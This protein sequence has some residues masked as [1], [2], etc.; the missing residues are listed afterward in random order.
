LKNWLRLLAK[1]PFSCNCRKGRESEATIVMTFSRGARLLFLALCFL[2]FPGS[3]PVH[4]LPVGY[5][6]VEIAPLSGGTES[7]AWDLNS[8][9][10]VVGLSDVGGDTVVHT[11][12]WTNGVS[13]DLGRFEVSVG[14]G[15]HINNTG[16]VV[17]S[18][19]FGSE[20]H[21]FLWENGITTD[22]GTLGGNR[23]QA[24]DVNNSGQV[25][26]VNEPSRHGFLW[27]NGSMIDLGTLGGSLST[28][29][30]I[31]KLGQI[32]GSS[33]LANEE[34]R[35]FIWENGTMSDLGT[36]PGAIDHGAKSINELGQVVGSI[37][38]SPV[39][40][41]AAFWDTTGA[42]DL[43]TLGGT[44]SQATDISNLG[45]IVG[46]SNLLGDMV[47]H[48][49]IWEDGVM[50][51]LND[52]LDPSASGWVLGHARGI[53]DSGQITG[54]GWLNG[55]ERAYLLNPIPEPSTALLVTFGFTGLA[56]ARRRIRAQ[57]KT[58]VSNARL[59]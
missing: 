42:F 7:A 48:G 52:L 5:T 56:L 32:V 39:E 47:N 36:I 26:G 29:A 34:G 54:V 11:F 45:Q 35:A 21:A 59:H 18:T 17:G 55:E 9:G 51:D 46:G 2:S 3:N 38:T 28:A 40:R 16:A 31:N 30:G 44:F 13:Q 25:V 24:W 1:N 22:L 33:T 37:L 41:H 4:A 6:V 19:Q 50:T 53:N 10:Q 58:S 8:S 23:S 57:K 12:L 27:E 20:V 14:T 43:G 49:Y 15:P